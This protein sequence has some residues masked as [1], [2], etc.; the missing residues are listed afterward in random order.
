MSL[1]KR[2]VGVRMKLGCLLV[3]VSLA[4]LSCILTDVLASHHSSSSDKDGSLSPGQIDPQ[5][6]FQIVSL[7][8]DVWTFMVSAMPSSDL[9]CSVRFRALPPQSWRQSRQ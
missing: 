4:L 5:S 3:R 6:M 1:S 7:Q 8:N 9:R 2:M